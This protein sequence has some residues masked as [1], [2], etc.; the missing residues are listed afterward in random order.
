MAERRGDEELSRMLARQDGRYASRVAEIYSI[1]D[2]KSAR[3]VGMIARCDIDGG[4]IILVEKP[5]HT[6]P[7]GYGRSFLR[8]SDV[9]P[10]LTA[11]DRY[12]YGR[13]TSSQHR[14]SSS[15][16]PRKYPPP[17]AEVRE[18]MDRMAEM[19]ATE[20]MLE[21]PRLDDLW[22]LHDAHNRAAAG[23]AVMIHGL[24]SIAGRKLNG[25]IGRVAGRDDED[26][27]RC[28]VEI[29]AGSGERR[30]RKSIKRDNLKTL[31]GIFRTNFFESRD[32]GK[33]MVFGTMSR[34]N[35]ACGTYAN[36]L[37][38][39]VDDDDSD[40]NGNGS[41]T[42]SSN[43]AY[44]VAGRDISMGEEIFIDY[45]PSDDADEDNDKGGDDDDHRRQRRLDS[46]RNQYNF[47]CQCPEH[48]AR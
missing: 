8:R 34:I 30:S 22:K 13:T 9:A 7:A 2:T 37:K 6:Q 3:G 29:A 46:L 21:S 40:G 19:N 12:G 45:V 42:T 44:L 47:R 4:E 5:L 28:A 43:K 36:A 20:R 32:G 17:P 18:A 27:D 25:R 31:G 15:G 39:I 10:L 24:V 38:L 1:S 48:S 41:G 26:A 23:D 11:I 35:H 16:D 33:Q 14:P